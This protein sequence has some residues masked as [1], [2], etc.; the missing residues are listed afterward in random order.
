M[1]SIQKLVGLN[2]KRLLKEKGITQ[3]DLARQIGVAFQTVNAYVNARQGISS[4]TLAKMAKGLDV[5]E[6][7]FFVLPEKALPPRTLEITATRE[8]MLNEVK[9]AFKLLDL[10]TPELA[11][12]LI[13][14]DKATQRLFVDGLKIWITLSND[15]QAGLFRMTIRRGEHNAGSSE[16][17]E[18]KRKT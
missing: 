8:D 7:E 5:S 14:A 4:D 15:E 17:Q 2:L 6:M 18:V 1:T 16:L 3:G 10:I 12:Q 11:E 9:T 13:K